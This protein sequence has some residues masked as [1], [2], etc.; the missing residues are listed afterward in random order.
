MVEVLPEFPEA[1]LNNGAALK[2][3]VTVVP[4]LFAVNPTENKVI[5]IGYGLLS[6][7]D[8]AERLYAY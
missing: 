6:E 3:N 1:K 7:D 4:S 2:L 8:L 5:P